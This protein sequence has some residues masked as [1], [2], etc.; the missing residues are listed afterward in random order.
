MPHNHEPRWILYH[1]IRKIPEIVDI[2]SIASK[3]DPAWLKELRPDYFA[4]NRVEWQKS[5]PW[6]QVLL[7][8]R[9]MITASM[10]SW[11]DQGRALCADRESNDAHWLCTCFRVEWSVRHEPRDARY[12]L[13]WVLMDEFIAH[14]LSDTYKYA[15]GWIIHCIST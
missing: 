7:R 5:S 11:R 3:I 10:Y 12:W 4:I 14:V 1:D 13:V 9:F 15:E 6:R 8:S 2:F